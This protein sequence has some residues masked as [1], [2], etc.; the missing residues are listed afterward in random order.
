MM[1][2]RRILS[3]GVNE[4]RKTKNRYCESEKGWLDK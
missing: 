2:V 3:E 4:G 1:E